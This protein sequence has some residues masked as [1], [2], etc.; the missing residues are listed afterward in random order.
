V[1]AVVLLSTSIGLNL[2]REFTGQSAGLN[3]LLSRFDVDRESNV[4]TFFSSFL[5]LF[6]AILLF[7]IS[8]LKRKS[9]APYALHWAILALGFLYLAVDESAQL[10]ELLISPSRRLLGS[11]GTEIFYLAPWVLPGIVITLALGLFYM[12]FFL[13][14][15]LKMKLLLLIAGTLFVGGSRG[16][17]LIGG[18]Y[19]ALYGKRDLRYIATAT[20]EEGLE[21]AGVIIFIHALLD[22]IAACYGE[23]RFRFEPFRA[24]A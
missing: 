1:T 24:G 18:F 2:V 15:S 5:L 14:L 23:V 19:S 17:E 20:V 9:G 22:Y 21:M 6:A 7:I 11:R 12:R 4:P 8:V 13:E 3:V 10:H 16:L